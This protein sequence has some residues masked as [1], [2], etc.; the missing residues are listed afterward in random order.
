VAMG[1]APHDAGAA[2]SL[3]WQRPDGEAMFRH[4]CALG[5]E[6]IVCK[7][8]DRPYRSD[9]SRDWIKVKNPDAPAV[10]RIVEIDWAT[11]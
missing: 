7:R 3:D 1:R 6:G 2:P 4:V 5:L 11:R 10:K 8:L 9:R